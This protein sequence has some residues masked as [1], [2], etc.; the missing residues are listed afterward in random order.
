[1]GRQSIGLVL[2]L[3]LA[4]SISA[5]AVHAQPVVRTAD[6]IKRGLKLT[7]VL[8]PVDAPAAGQRACNGVAALGLADSP[9]PG[10][11]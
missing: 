5:A 10:T 3:F 2:C 4:L 6:P 7:A 9:R 8:L 1:M 11:Y